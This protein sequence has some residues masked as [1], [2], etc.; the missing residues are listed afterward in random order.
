MERKPN[1]LLSGCLIWI[2]A[3]LLISGCLVPASLFVAGM[4]TFFSEE[5]IVPIL[6]PYMCPENTNA[7]I[8]SFESTMIGQDRFVRPSTTLEMICKSP[9]GITVQNL[10][11]SY[12]FIW[13]GIFVVVGLILAAIFAIILTFVFLRITRKK[14]NHNSPSPPLVKIQ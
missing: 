13:S 7:E 12:A 9:D 2:I 8:I 14:A 6:G 3:F 11:G 5:F 1:R 4:S 10:G